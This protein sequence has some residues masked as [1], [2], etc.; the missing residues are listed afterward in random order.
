MSKF[1]RTSLAAF[2]LAVPGILLAA[3]G[4]EEESAEDFPS[5]EVEMIIPWSPGGGSDIEGRV[6]AEHLEDTLDENVVVTNIDGVGGTVGMEELLQEEANGYHI[7]QIH[8]GHLV[9]EH[10]GVTSVDFTEEFTPLAAMSS[11]DQILAVSDDFEAQSLEDFV[12]YG[13]ENTIQFGGTVSGIPRVWTE[14]MADA[15][16]IDHEMVGYEGLGEAIQALAGGHVDAVIVDYPSASEFVEAGDMHFVAAGTDERIEQIDDVPTFQ[17]EG[18]DFNMSLY[19]GYVAPADT[20]DEIV[21]VLGDYFEETAS[22]DEYVDEINDLGAEVDFM[23][24]E[25]YQEHLDEQ[26]EM[27]QETVEEIDMEEE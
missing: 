23:G 25:A 16:E 24:P 17:E 5:R 1:K 6:V 26:D 15:L 13:Q 10:T 12:E 4:G 14:Q 19:R 2:T 11:A 9:A 8:E 22:Q 7:G 20:P 18:Y 27:I 21:E 3:C